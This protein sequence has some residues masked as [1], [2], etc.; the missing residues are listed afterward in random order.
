MTR[1]KMKKTKLLSAMIA[2]TLSAS[3][4]TEAEL[5]APAGN[6]QNYINASTE[7]MPYG[8]SDDWWERHEALPDAAQLKAARAARC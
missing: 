7:L 5:T 4:S 8:D 1:I 2:A 3:M 6:A